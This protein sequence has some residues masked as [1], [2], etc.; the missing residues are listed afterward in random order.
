[1]TWKPLTRR[2]ILYRTSVWYASNNCES[3]RSWSHLRTRSC[4]CCWKRY[5]KPGFSAF[6]YFFSNVNN[7]HCTLNW[8][9]RSL[10]PAVG[11]TSGMLILPFG[12]TINIWMDRQEQWVALLC[13]TGILKWLRNCNYIICI[14]VNKIKVESIWYYKTARMV[15][16]WTWDTIQNG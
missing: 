6:D 13:I 2:S 5:F 10:N 14:R 15:G 1:M 9:C 8:R 3:T 7:Y 12:A 4:T 16:P 11:S